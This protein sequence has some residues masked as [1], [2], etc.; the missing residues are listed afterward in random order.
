MYKEYMLFWW[1]D[2]LYFIAIVLVTLF[3]VVVPRMSRRLSNNRSNQIQRS[4]DQY[5]LM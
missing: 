5:A 3:Y 2:F 4:C 1:K